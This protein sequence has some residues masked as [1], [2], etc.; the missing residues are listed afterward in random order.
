[1]G[2]EEAE[3]L[4][5][6]QRRKL[7]L[8]LFTVCSLIAAAVVLAVNV[9]VEGRLSW[10]LYPLASIAWLWLLVAI[11]Q[12]LRRHPWLS[13]AVLGPSSLLFLLAL[14]SV[15]GSLDWFPTMGLPIG[16]LLEGLAVACAVLSA[17]A[18]RKGINVIAIVLSGTVAACVGVELLINLNFAG[19]LFLSWSAI[20]AIA[21]LP[22][23]GFLFYMH[24]R[25]VNRAS[26]RKLFHL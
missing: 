14:D 18:K 3:D 9:L 7:F 8:E 4:T 20:V 22:L 23:A 19:R 24:Y 15:D 1:M 21:G 26:L 25:I 13:F 11:P 12:I 16:L 6:E 2:L 5:P 10:S 17:A